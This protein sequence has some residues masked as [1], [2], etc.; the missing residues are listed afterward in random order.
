MTKAEIYN[1]FCAYFNLQ[2]ENLSNSSRRR[3]GGQVNAEL[4][5]LAHIYIM[6]STYT[7]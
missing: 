4:V 2:F 5:S 3:R 1:D 6:Y 7:E